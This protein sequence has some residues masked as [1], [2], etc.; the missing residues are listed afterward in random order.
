MPNMKEQDKS[1]DTEQQPPFG[2]RKV[3]I[4]QIW[5]LYLLCFKSYGQGKSCLPQSHRQGKN[6]MLPNSISGA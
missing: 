1:S 2:D 3:S 4:S 6:K 5:S